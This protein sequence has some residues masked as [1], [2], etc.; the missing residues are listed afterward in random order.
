MEFKNRFQSALR[1]GNSDEE[2]LKMARLEGRNDDPRRVYDWLQELWMEAG[3]HERS[4]GG[5][6]QDQLEFV[7][8]KIWQECPVG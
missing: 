7:M 4:D 1:E 3:F 6:I 8:E 5:E 2:L